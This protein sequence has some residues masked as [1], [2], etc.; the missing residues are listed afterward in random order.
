MLCDPALHLLEHSLRGGG[1]GEEGKGKQVFLV[2]LP[3]LVEM[4]ATWPLSAGPPARREHP[5]RRTWSPPAVGSST[6]TPSLHGAAGGPS[7]PTLHPHLPSPAQAGP[8]ESRGTGVGHI[9]AHR[10]LPGKEAWD[11]WLNLS[12]F[13]FS[14]T[15]KNTR[16]TSVIVKIK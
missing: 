3:E 1:R 7:R 13:I 11:R 16:A 4:S 10:L 14:H 9:A 8:G 2:P 6:R 15:T 12:N 5:V